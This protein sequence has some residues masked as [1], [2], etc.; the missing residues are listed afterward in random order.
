M[1]YFFTITCL[2]FFFILFKSLQ[3]DP[4]LLPSNLISKEVPKFSINTFKNSNFSNI[5]LENEKVVIVN[6]FASWCPPCRIEHKNLLE[7]SKYTKVFGV[8]KK[9]K[10]NDLLLWLEE[11]GNPY[12]K[13]AMDY[14]GLL[15]IDW[16]VYGL[17]ET[18]LI[19]NGFIKYRH[20]GPIMERDLEIFNN[21]TKGLK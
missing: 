10:K 11:L 14:D 13:I 4:Q 21:F 7:L 1:K 18:F 16:G 20:V 8:A 9:N 17:P 19:V 12:K 2:I 3:K 6:F 15:S 5:D